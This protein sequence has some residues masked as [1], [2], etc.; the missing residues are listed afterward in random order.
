MKRATYLAFSFCLVTTLSSA[1]EAPDGDKYWPQWRG[2]HANGVATEGAPPVKWS[3]TENVRWKIDLPGKGSSTPI[4]WGDHLFVTTAIPA[5]EEKAPEPPPQQG[6][7]EQR[8]GPR[9]LQPK[10]PYEFV[11]FAIHRRDGRIVWQKTLREE[12]PH[13][14]THPTGTFASN[15]AVTDGSHIW[16]YFG[17]RGLYCLDMEGNLIW[18]RD[19][20]DMEKRRTFGEGS[21]PVL[22]DDK[23][24]VLWD[25]QG[26]SSL[27]ALDKKTGK[28]V[29]KVDRDEIT[30]WTTPLIVEHDGK[31]QIVTSA[32]ELVRSYDTETGELIWHTG[33]MTVNPIP[34]PVSIDGLVLV[35]S[36]FRGNA[37]LAIRLADAKGDITDSDAIV[38]S[39]DKDTPYAPSPLL[40]DDI[41]YFTKTNS[42]ILSVFNAKTGEDYY[43]LRRLPSL[44]NIYSSPVGVN[45]HVYISDREGH[46]LVIRHGR[47]FEV[48]AENTLDDGFD[49]SLAVAGDEIYMRGHENLYCIASNNEDK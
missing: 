31:H 2:P 3:E 5:V 15:S 45:G 46:T 20:G 33:G 44:Q 21:S 40:Y 18:E 36:G 35:T 17:S 39:L 29:W 42:G 24:F 38:W 7:S 37:L 19:F 30:S 8:R 49:A 43:R 10:G 26:P 25:H 27:F 34:S 23:I 11:L 14:G 32:T 1:V 22:H 9:T 41:L 6:Q 28:D 16:A 13:E 12:V 48:I 4:I 47:E